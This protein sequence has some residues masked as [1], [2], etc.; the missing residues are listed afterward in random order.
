MVN[1]DDGFANIGTNAILPV[2]PRKM[3]LLIGSAQYI[4]IEVLVSQLVR[5]IM[6][7]PK[8]WTDLIFIHTLSLPF[9][10]G[11]AGFADDNRELD[12]NPKVWSELFMDGA[13][14]IP[15][16]LL[17]QWVLETFYTGFHFPW[18]NM[19]DLLITAGAKTISRPISA[20]IVPYLPDGM[21]DQLEVCQMM[22]TLQSA[23]STLRTKASAGI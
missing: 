11:A 7:A 18:F 12:K 15:A 5:F 10:G 13:K 17:A 20:F 22:I 14:G 21:Q 16:V 19:K 9:M 6:K 8:G 2:D 4:A 1:A 23:N 3:K